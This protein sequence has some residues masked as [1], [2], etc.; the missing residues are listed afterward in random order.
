M[1]R[2][3]KFLQRGSITFCINFSSS[4]TLSSIIKP[5]NVKLILLFAEFF[6][7]PKMFSIL[8]INI[9]IEAMI[10]SQNGSA[11]I[12]NIIKVSRGNQPKIDKL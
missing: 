11:H 2:L 3:K 10:G 12:S 8:P 6:I 1:A 9:L 4:R 5:Y 7:I